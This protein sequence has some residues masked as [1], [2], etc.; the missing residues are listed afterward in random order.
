ML[1]RGASQLF[2][3]V[4][5]L[6]PATGG[7]LPAAAPRGALAEDL[8]HAASIPLQPHGALADRQDPAPCRRAS[9]RGDPHLQPAGL[10]GL[11]AGYFSRAFRASLGTSPHAFILERRLARARAMMLGTALGLSEIA[12]ECGFC[13]QP[14]LTKRFRRAMGVSPAAWRRGQG[15]RP[16]AAR[17]TPPESVLQGAAA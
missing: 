17:A 5:S 3:A 12:Q 13:D 1:Q 4:H 15:R 11:S 9:G 16:A 7:T 2:T 6:P 10:V 8:D 14:H